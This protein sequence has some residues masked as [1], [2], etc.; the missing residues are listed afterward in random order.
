[1]SIIDP[2]NRIRDSG[3]KSSK[4]RMS[5]RDAQE[6]RKLDAAVDR[7]FNAV[8]DNPYILSVPCD[9]P[10]FHYPSRQEAHSWQRHTPFSLDEERLQYMTYI[11]RDPGD[12]CFVVRSQV[13]EDRDRQKAQHHAEKAPS[14][15]SGTSTPSQG[16]KK[17][18]SLSAYKTKIAG[19]PVEYKEVVPE[20]VP[21]KYK[22]RME[23]KKVNGVKA[24]PTP[25]RSLEATQ[26]PPASSSKK[27]LV[28][29]SRRLYRNTDILQTTCRLQCFEIINRSQRIAPSSQEATNDHTCTA[30]N[31]ILTRLTIKR[32]A[33]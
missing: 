12:S 9:E 16:T 2:P 10:R 23:E 5:N 14:F 33:P 21:E 4:P 27:R 17:K 22:P 8:P 1:M 15:L 24:G 13:D 28:G 6:L 25:A 29:S 18:L 11:Y 7:I 19:G 26:T 3:R 31:Q 32:R 30:R 20:K